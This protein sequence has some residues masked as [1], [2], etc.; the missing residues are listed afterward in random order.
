MFNVRWCVTLLFGLQTIPVILASSRF[1]SHPSLQK[2]LV[3]K[4]ALHLCRVCAH[5][6]TQLVAEGSTGKV[7]AERAH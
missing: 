7:I 1:I 3:V 4:Q 6:L 5:V 2:P